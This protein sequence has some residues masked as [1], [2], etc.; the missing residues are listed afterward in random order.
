M[1][2]RSDAARGPAPRA[3]AS[4]TTFPVGR[5]S[6]GIFI[7]HLPP[8]TER[9]RERKREKEKEEKEE[10]QRKKE[11]GG[12]R[13]RDRVTVPETERKNVSSIS[14]QELTLSIKKLDGSVWRARQLN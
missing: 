8:R 9:K 6:P 11:G 1:K 2:F 3:R 13:G 4:P 7:E 14:H 5:G 12:N 10:K